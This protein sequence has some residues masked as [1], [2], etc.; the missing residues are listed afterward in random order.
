MLDASSPIPGLLG[1]FCLVS[2]G[3]FFERGGVL[4]FIRK[5]SFGCITEGK[6]NIPRSHQT[7]ENRWM[8]TCSSFSWNSICVP[9]IGEMANKINM[10]FLGTLFSLK[11]LNCSVFLSIK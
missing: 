3:F 8:E 2:F 10:I 5:G 1:V 9:T 6:L 7:C 4:Y 11:Q